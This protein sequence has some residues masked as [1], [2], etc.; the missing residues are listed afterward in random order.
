MSWFGLTALLLLLVAV[1]GFANHVWV[2]LPRTIALLAGA[3]LVSVAIVAAEPWLPM[4]HL[5]EW[6][7]DVVVGNDLPHVF[8]DGVL[9]FM[10]F[11]GAMHVDIAALRD[12]KW[13][14]LTLATFGVLASTALY[15]FGLYALFTAHIPLSWCFVLG[16]ILAPTD[17]IAV[18]ELIRRVGLPASLQAIIAG[19]SLFN[20]GVAVVVFGICLSIAT[21]SGTPDGIAIAGDFAKE[22]LGGAT[23][24]LLT[25]Y[26]AYTAM[27]RVDEHNLELTISLALVTG[28]YSLAHYLAVSGPIAVVVAGLLIGH[29]AA[30]YA[31]SERTRTNVTTFWELIDQLLNAILFL[32]LG[33]TLLALEDA[34]TSAVLVAGGVALAVLVRLVSVGLPVVF[35]GLPLLRMARGVAVLTWGG[36]RGG[37]SIA[38]ALTLPPSAYRSDLLTLCYAVVVFTILAQGLTMPWLIRRLYGASVEES[39]E[40]GHQP[41]HQVHADQ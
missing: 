9:A 32:V 3:L 26:V 40:D 11:A 38:L 33:F 30:R 1:L 23:L 19:E 6:W 34:N 14:V 13:I 21:G 36:L 41:Q 31:W 27:R 28:T 29:R 15:G 2:G 7:Q 5:H 24:G 17:P 8:L 37:I 12:A 22:A 20:D 25:G 35:A 18:S 16:S 4:V 10:L 39:N